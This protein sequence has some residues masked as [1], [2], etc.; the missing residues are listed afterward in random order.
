VL[1]DRGD[2]R[3]WRAA[4]FTTMRKQEEGAR[5]QRKA[6]WLD[7]IVVLLTRR[8]WWR[9]WCSP[10]KERDRGRQRLVCDRPRGR[11][12]HREGAPVGGLSIEGPQ[13]RAVLGPLGN[14]GTSTTMPKLEARRQA[15]LHPRSRRSPKLRLGGR[16][17]K[18]PSRAKAWEGGDSGIERFTGCSCRVLVAEV[19]ETHLPCE[20]EAYRKVCRVT[21]G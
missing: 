6:L 21:S 12:R 7:E 2:C 15:R 11:I 8:R 9:V 3:R 10:R 17:W 14:R 19:G 1:V 16:S 5:R 20:G 4:P 18:P 13:V